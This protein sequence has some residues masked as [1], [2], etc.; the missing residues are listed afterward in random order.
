MMLIL[1]SGSPR[2]KSIL[3]AVLGHVSVI[4]PH[5]DE[6]LRPGESPEPYVRRVLADKME[7]IRNSAPATGDHLIIVSDTI[8]T[9]DNLVL[10]K[11][12]SREEAADMLGLLSG[13]EHHV[14]TGLGLY[15]RKNGNGFYTRAIE[16]TAVTFKPL[17]RDAI[18]RYLDI[19]PYLDKAGSYAIQ[20]NGGLIIDAV[21]GSVT[22]VIGFPLG[23]FFSMLCDLGIAGEVL[24]I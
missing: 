22:N 12:S 21:S 24:G 13:R 16:D 6:T 4:V 2:R 3:E 5:A 8:V 15:L 19:T 1:G 23:L 20:E 10:G 9:I 17:D 11:P 18:N 7:S 14:L